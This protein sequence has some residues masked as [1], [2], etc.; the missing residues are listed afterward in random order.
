MTPQN[1]GLKKFAQVCQ[2]LSS[3]AFSIFS[4]TSRRAKPDC[5][6]TGDKAYLHIAVSHLAMRNTLALYLL[7]LKYTKINI[8]TMCKGILRF[9]C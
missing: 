3:Y 2:D 4:S 9:I 6:K 8:A 5:A 1:A 7:G